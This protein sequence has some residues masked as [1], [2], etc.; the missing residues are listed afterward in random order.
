MANNPVDIA[1]QAHVLVGR[2]VTVYTRDEEWGIVVTPG[3][4]GHVSECVYLTMAKDRTERGLPPEVVRVMLSTI[5]GLHP[6]GQGDVPAGQLHTGHVLRRGPLRGAKITAV[7]TPPEFGLG[8]V[9]L[10]CRTSRKTETVWSDART[11]LPT[12][13][14]PEG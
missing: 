12:T 2:N 14:Q 4:L 1:N 3:L 6:Q 9:R 7:K 11:C 8:V 13:E 5:I 10:S